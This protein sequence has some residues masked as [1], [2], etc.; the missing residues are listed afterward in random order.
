MRFSLFFVATVAVAA[1]AATFGVTQLAHARGE[2]SSSAAA[3]AAAL[4]S[5]ASAS[6]SALG[7][8]RFP[9]ASAYRYPDAR[10]T[11][12]TPTPNDPL[13]SLDA[14]EA[15]I[16]RH[17]FQGVPP[18]A[19]FAFAGGDVATLG[20]GLPSLPFSFVNVFKTSMMNTAAGMKNLLAK[21]SKM[22]DN[23]MDLGKKL[24]NAV[25]TRYQKVDC[26]MQQ[27][28]GAEIEDRL[29]PDAPEK[30]SLGSAFTEVVDWDLVRSIIHSDI[31]DEPLSEDAVRARERHEAMPTARL[32]WKFFADCDDSTD[33]LQN[34]LAWGYADGDS[35]GMPWPEKRKNESFAPM[36]V[37]AGMG[38]GVRLCI[39]KTPIDVD[40]AASKDACPTEKLLE[41]PS[42][43]LKS[44][45]SMAFDAFI[46][47]ISPVLDLIAFTINGFLEGVEWLWA[48]IRSFTCY[49]E[50]K[51]GN[52]NPE[53][54]P[55][56]END[57]KLKAANKAFD[58][59]QQVVEKECKTDVAAKACKDAEGKADAA[60]AEMQERESQLVDLANH[61]AELTKLQ[62]EQTKKK[63]ALDNLKN[64]LGPLSTA[65]K[66]AVDA[67]ETAQESSAGGTAKRSAADKAIDDEADQVDKIKKADEEL[68]ALAMSIA[69]LQAKIN[70]DETMD[71]DKPPGTSIREKLTQ[72][73]AKIN[74]KVTAGEVFDADGK[75]EK[76][77]N[78][79]PKPSGNK[80]SWK[81][82]VVEGV[83]S[84][85]SY[86]PHYFMSH[87]GLDADDDSFPPGLGT[88]LGIHDDEN[89]DAF[90]GE[91]EEHL[92]GEVKRITKDL[93]NSDAA[94]D[95][96]ANL[97]G[98]DEDVTENSVIDK[99]DMKD[100]SAIKL[101]EHLEFVISVDLPGFKTKSTQ[102]GYK[103]GYLMMEECAQLSKKLSYIFGFNSKWFGQMMELKFTADFE[104]LLP[105]SF[106]HEGEMIVDIAFEFRWPWTVSTDAA[107]G[108]SLA[109]KPPHIH[110]S[111]H[112]DQI[113]FGTPKEQTAA[114]QVG[115]SFKVL[116]LH[117]EICAKIPWLLGACVGPHFQ[118]FWPFAVGVDLAPT[119]ADASPYFVDLEYEEA[120][121]TK[122]KDSKKM[123]L[124]KYF[125]A[126]VPEYKLDIRITF[127]GFSI[128]ALNAALAAAKKK[129]PSE[130]AEAVVGT[131]E[132]HI[133]LVHI[134]PRKELKFPN[135]KTWIGH[136]D[137][138]AST[139][140]VE[141]VGIADMHV[142]KTA[143]DVQKEEKQ[144]EKEAADKATAVKKYNKEYTI[145]AMK[146]FKDEFMDKVKGAVNEA[147]TKKIFLG[148]TDT[149]GN[150]YLA[151][152]KEV[153]CVNLAPTAKKSAK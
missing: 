151:V 115:L 135:L 8:L 149:Q 102:N 88:T 87:L 27:K 153:T 41:I 132:P 47:A 117:A 101:T 16:A 71:L 116:K 127:E 134:W 22:K 48:K 30:A 45:A 21:L 9:L 128:K 85:P 81:K 60:A 67:L 53:K 23:V 152:Y 6:A 90:L 94:V 69:D 14:R 113:S 7:G 70:D 52:P 38:L 145:A 75:I 49:L 19:Q 44:I 118:M 144:N 83:T 62:A 58:K 28:Y 123:A 139:S 3:A 1:A 122:C 92:L 137:N 56:P 50:R 131:A 54:C 32:G 13:Y 133:T 74:P 103:G 43:L 150:D 42:G 120:D 61:K 148:V 63:T 68:E 11:P 99:L 65:K 95:V 136:A 86:L 108:M 96:S 129:D 91:L 125:Y 143:A 24:F 72:T 25:Y 34:D 141:P 114:I 109:K 33:D 126:G 98:G 107:D 100:V 106:Y 147:K 79:Q 82:S 40:T 111:G 4:G 2:A 110:L 10:A 138:V 46:A 57:K 78:D 64:A 105:W 73:W 140:A 124:G 26:L 59:D 104:I 15:R 18:G 77:V 142:A 130:D 39:R 31:R 93:R 37:K 20:V 80:K 5:S 119:S 12:T 89:Y 76:S 84:L 51:R 66:T 97:G 146:A 17:F 29:G 36:E 55:N 35:Y 121:K 112:N